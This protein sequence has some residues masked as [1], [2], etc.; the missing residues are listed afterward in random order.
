VKKGEKGVGWVLCGIRVGSG[1]LGLAGN[2]RVGGASSKAGEQLFAL[3]SNFNGGR[4]SQSPSSNF[5]C[6]G[7]TFRFIEQVRM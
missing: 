5:A 1:G 3:G 4:A 7:A 2:F 6:D